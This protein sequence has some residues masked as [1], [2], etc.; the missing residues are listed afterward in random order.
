MKV[1]GQEVDEKIIARIQK[2]IDSQPDLS[3]VK[4]SRQICEELGWRARN[5]RLKEVSCRVV[6][7]KLRRRG[8]I[9]LT[10][11]APFPAQRRKVAK[12]AEV[13]TEV[14]IEGPLAKFQPIEIIRI[15]SS[16][17]AE[18]GIWND[19]MEEHHYLGA[20]PL[21]GSQIRYLIRSANE[22]WL[23]GMA[24]SAAAW[25]VEARDEWIG[26]DAEGREQNLHQVV[27]NSR[28]L[29]LP[30]VRVPHLASHVIGLVLRRL[31]SDWRG[32]Y[33]YE[34][35]LVETFVEA[36]RFAGTCYRA[37]NFVEVGQTKGRGR[38]DCRNLGGRPVKRVLMYEWS[39]QAREQL[40]KADRRSPRPAPTAVSKDWAEGEFGRTRL[41]DERLRKRLVTMARD[42]YA[43]PQAQIPEACQSRSKT[44]AAY[45]FLDH[46]ETGMEILLE[47]HYQATQQR[48]GEHKIVLSV[49]DTTS[50]NYTAHPATKDLGPISTRVDGS[51][52]LLVHD[53][54]AFSV[55]GTPLGL[56]DVQCW[57]RDQSEFGKHHQRKQR[58]IEQKE[59]FKWLKS[60]QRTAEAQRQCPDTMLIS[61]G[62]READI[63]ELLDLALADPRGPK[64][65]VR[66]EH[67]RLLAEGQEH[68]W[69]MVAGQPVAASQDLHVPR[70]GVQPKRVAHMEIRFAPVLLKPPGTK[71]HLPSLKL[72][73]V[74][75]QEARASQGV[76]P[77]QWMLLTTCEVHN[78]A[79]AIEKVNW[80][81]LR[82]GI[83][84]YH[85]TLKSGCKIEDRQLGAADRIETC[86]AID[87]VVAWRIFHLAKLGREVPDVPCTV[88]FEE[89]EWK[90]LHTHITK[91]PVPPS[92][93]PTLNQAMR[94]VATL[95]GFLGRK[96]DGEPGTTTLWRG[97]QYLD[98]IAAMWK[99]M[100][101]QHAPHLLSTPVSRASTYG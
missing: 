64:L 80:Y 34:P 32:R 91:T 8:V 60:F 47:S 97:L 16:R 46:R 92:D 93:P 18:S 54:M 99:Y 26:W 96:N 75:A 33:G 45:R 52:G 19:L 3:R 87:M 29:I 13:W 84:V 12:A 53:T 7:G 51:M 2:A 15:D 68:L 94:M 83:E 49:Q 98:G 28:F 9:R 69:A 41:P 4:L 78:A 79:D 17:S 67:D 65:L 6:L 1:G 72:W 66:A 31:R 62:D 85:R 48:I 39:G 82:W 56:L 77:L 23:G 74:L 5:G 44:K 10:E 37:S 27:D 42:L 73:A 50:L 61:V 36:E 89:F 30:N 57:A 11:V 100:V 55:E 20:G 58:P 40:C 21:C 35:L 76:K 86:L 24:F 88:F 101:I 95:G 90:A 43:R 14:K 22:G 25:R 70:R 71:T 81:R 63:Y 59:S 38:Q